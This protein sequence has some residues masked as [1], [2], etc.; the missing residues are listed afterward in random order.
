[1]TSSLRS[2]AA[3]DIASTGG[4]GSTLT[5]AFGAVLPLGQRIAGLDG[6]ELAERDGVAGLGGGALAVMGAAHRRDAGHPAALAR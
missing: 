1:M 4:I 5:S 2:A 6:V 3:I